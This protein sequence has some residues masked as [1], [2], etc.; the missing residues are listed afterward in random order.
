[1]AVRSPP[2]LRPLAW[3]RLR[4]DSHGMTSPGV[5]VRRFFD[6]TGKHALLTGATGAL[7]R[8]LAVALA[9]AGANVSLTT[10]HDDPSEEVRAHSILNECWSF[11]RKGEVRRVD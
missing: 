6:L 4:R 1:M 9:D 7:Q 8:A 5:S 10:L 11:G 2:E 3:F